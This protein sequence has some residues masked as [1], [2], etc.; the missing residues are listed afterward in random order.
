MVETG[1]TPGGRR[2]RKWTQR[3]EDLKCK[4]GKFQLLSA[5]PVCHPAFMNG[6]GGGL[7]RKN[8]IKIKQAHEDE[9]QVKNQRMEGGVDICP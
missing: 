2:D 1:R 8:K 4:R 9:V 7:E 3:C 5:V 6:G